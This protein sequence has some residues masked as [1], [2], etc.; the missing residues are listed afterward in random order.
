[1][2]NPDIVPGSQDHCGPGMI[3]EVFFMEQALVSEENLGEA[4]SDLQIRAL[5]FRFPGSSSSLI[6]RL[7][8]A[9][10]SHNQGRD[11]KAAVHRVRDMRLARIRTIRHGRGR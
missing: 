7:H 11:G 5:F 10:N 3:G 9:S 8:E 6:G 2:I 1:M 4:L